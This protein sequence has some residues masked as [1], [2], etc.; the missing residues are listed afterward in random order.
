LSLVRDLRPP[1]PLLQPLLDEYVVPVLF[2]RGLEAVPNLIAALPAIGDALWE[3]EI[4][5][6]WAMQFV[7][8]LKAVILL[9]S[10]ANAAR[11]QSRLKA[12]RLLVMV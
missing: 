9:V 5:Q 1:P 10:S 11:I 6:A 12:R 8:T 4:A 3:V 7:V 2:G